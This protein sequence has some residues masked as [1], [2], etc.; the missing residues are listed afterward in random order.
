[1]IPETTYRE[2]SGADFARLTG[3]GARRARA[4]LRSGAVK[5]VYMTPGGQFR[6]AEW[7]LAEWQRERGAARGASNSTDR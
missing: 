4:I 3:M 6:F 5:T 1:M 7:A 2:L